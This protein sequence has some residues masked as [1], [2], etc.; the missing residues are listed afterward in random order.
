MK[1]EYEEIEI[2]LNEHDVE[3]FST[4]APKIEIK[5]DGEVLKYAKRIV[6]NAPFIN[7]I[8]DIQ[9][10]SLSVITWNPDNDQ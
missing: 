4:K 10:R 7:N 1:P 9:K 6:F 3:I 2:D 5:V 8:G